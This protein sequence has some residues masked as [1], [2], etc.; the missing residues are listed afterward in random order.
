MI[1][2]RKESKFKILNSKPIKRI[3][4]DERTLLGKYKYFYNKANGGKWC[5]NKEFDWSGT[6]LYLG[7]EMDSQFDLEDG[8]LYIQCYADGGMAW[9]MF[10][11]EAVKSMT[12][13]EK[14]CAEYTIN[15]LRDLEKA[16][17]IEIPKS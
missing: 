9:F 6:Y 7:C 15:Y 5:H 17:I 8:H 4:E 3:T 12:G 10:D 11:E 2:I 1:E 14:D 13:L 16:G